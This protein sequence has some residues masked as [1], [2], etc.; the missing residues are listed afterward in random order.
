LSS[1]PG[2]NYRLQPARPS[3]FL[4]TGSSGRLGS[5]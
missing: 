2:C 3:S 1:I 5:S 4:L